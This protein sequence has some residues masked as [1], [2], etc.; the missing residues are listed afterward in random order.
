MEIAYAIALL[1]VGF[2]LLLLEVFIP[3]LG[4]L[5]LMAMAAF[6][7]AFYFA[8]EVSPVFG[9]T[10]IGISA[11]GIPTAIILAFKVFPKTALG[12]HMILFRPKREESTEPREQLRAYA[13]KSGVTVSTLRPSGIARIDGHRLDVITRGEMIDPGVIVRVIEVLGNRIVV[14]AVSDAPPPEIDRELS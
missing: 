8:F 1:I 13:G 14:R 12:K 5:A 9:W 6:F 2:F 11:A 7:G 4:A 3:S 10:L